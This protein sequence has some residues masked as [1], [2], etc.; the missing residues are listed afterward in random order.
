MIISP[1]IKPIELGIELLE[2]LGNRVT[3]GR[4]NRN[5]TF[6]VAFTVYQDDSQRGLVLGVPNGAHL[7]GPQSGRVHQLEHG[8]ISLPE[9]SRIG[10]RRLEQRFHLPRRHDSGE[11]FPPR[12]GDP[13]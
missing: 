6:S 7:R 13:W 2:I 12:W 9:S 3:G 8:P 4:A 1:I 10:S 11:A 5:K